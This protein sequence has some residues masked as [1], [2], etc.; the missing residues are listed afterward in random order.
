MLDWNSCSGEEGV[1]R[2]MIRKIPEITSEGIRYLFCK[3]HEI[4]NHLII[5]INNTSNKNNN[6]NNN[7]NMKI[8]ISVQ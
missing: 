1:P 8:I 3:E 6:N 2:F 5:T 4:E 7:N